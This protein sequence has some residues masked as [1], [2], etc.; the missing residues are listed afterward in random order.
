MGQGVIEYWYCKLIIDRA[1]VVNN[2]LF[3]SVRERA[4]F[5]KSYNLIGS[6]AGGIFPSGPLLA[7]GIDIY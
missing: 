1:H 4:E 6:G 3:F 7:G 5:N 2:I